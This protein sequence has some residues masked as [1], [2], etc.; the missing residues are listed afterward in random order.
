MTIVEFADYVLSF[1]GPGKMYDMG[2]T[3]DEVLIASGVR[4]ERCRATDVPF[5][6]DS[7]DRE[8]VRDIVLGLRGKWGVGG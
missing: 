2:A 1:Y 3:R 6:G 4:M 5:D 8:A 7:I